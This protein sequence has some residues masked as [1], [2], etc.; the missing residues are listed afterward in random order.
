MTGPILD[1]IYDEP[2]LVALAGRLGN[3]LECGDC[4]A[5]RGDLGTGKTTFARAMIRAFVDDLLLDVPSPTFPIRQ[6]YA[7]QRGAIVHFDLYRIVAPR[8]LDEIGFDDALANAVTVI[9]WPE[10]AGSALPSSR[11]DIELS[12][13]SASDTRRVTIGGDAAFI[14]RLARLI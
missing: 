9:E 7:S 2:A 8:D 12:D 6:D 5:L 1:T 11:I 13:T 14:A 3:M 10:R 4:V